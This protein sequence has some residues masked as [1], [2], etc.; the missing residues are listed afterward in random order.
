MKLQFR[1]SRRYSVPNQLKSSSSQ[2]DSRHLTSVSFLSASMRLSSGSGLIVSVRRVSVSILHFAFPSHNFTFL[3]I[4]VSS[5]VV[6]TLCRFPSVLFSSVSDQVVS[7]LCQ[8]TSVRCNA[9]PCR[10]V[11]LLR[12]SLPNQIGSHLINS[13]SWQ[14][15]ALPIRIF[16]FLRFSKSAHFAS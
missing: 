14:F 10:I 8:F 1:P 2:G 12:H 16:S 5:P 11:S 6:S 7:H 9:F 4:S 15:L 13:N 3:V